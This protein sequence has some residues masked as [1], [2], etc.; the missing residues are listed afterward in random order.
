VLALE[1]VGGEVFLQL[2]TSR[3][4]P[5]V[6][7]EPRER[8]AIPPIAPS[9]IEPFLSKPLVV[10]ATELDGLPQII[11][12]EED[13]VALGRGNTAYAEHL[14]PEDTQWQIFRRGDPLIDP[15]TRALLGYVAVYLG[16]ARLVARGDISKIEITKSA[17]EIY[18]GDR[19]L[20]ISKERPIFSYI[21]HAPQTAVRGRVISTYGGLWETGPLAIVAL[22]RGTRD[23]LEVGHVLALYRDQRN[24][25]YVQRTEPLWGRTGPTGNDD[26]LPYYPAPLPA[27]DSELYDRG[28]PV[29]DADFEK[30][31]AE[32][33]G[34]VMVFRTF[35]RA[36]F[37]LV[38][39]AHRPVAVSDLVV[40]P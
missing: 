10:T 1:R 2:E 39:Q 35:E 4:S 25:R 32:R 29:R 16:E 7:A 27:R 26:R 13:R 30:L 18:R 11:A 40:N 36:S 33:Y 31:P 14:G 5:R 21:P 19:L 15:E 6:R 17:Q 9:A 22:S 28:Q 23:G 38:M 34:L 24:A 3:L 20:P 37:G 12:T 8:E